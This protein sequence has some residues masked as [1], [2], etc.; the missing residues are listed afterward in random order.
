MT[1][2]DWDASFG[3]CVGMYLNGQGIRHRGPRGERLV[4][5]H[6][7]L[8]CNAH[9]DV[10]TCRLPTREFG[11]RWEVVID[12]GAEL[13]GS[14]IEAGTT[15]DLLAHSM[16]VLMEAAPAAVA[17]TDPSIAPSIAVVPPIGR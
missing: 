4:D 17:E 8:Y 15:I 13:A 12:T 5:R 11:E 10:V 3:R 9:T 2:A 16:V 7:L 1:P 14:E 6:A